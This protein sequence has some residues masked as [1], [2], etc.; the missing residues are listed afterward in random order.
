MLRNT[1]TYYQRIRKKE[2]SKA[3][4]IIA[5]FIDQPS[6]KTPEGEW[7]K[8]YQSLK[9]IKCFFLGILKK[10]L[11]KSSLKNQVILGV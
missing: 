6:R 3:S 4:K 5:R 2:I 10:N 7:N 1:V 11:S 9:T 8:K